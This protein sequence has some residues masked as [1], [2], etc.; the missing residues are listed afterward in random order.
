MSEDTRRILE[1]LSEGKISVEE[2][3]RL[4]AAVGGTGDRDAASSRSKDGGGKYLFVRV[5]PTEGSD[6]GGKGDRVN[7]RVPLA[8]LRAGAKL[9]ALMP[10]A[11]GVKVSDALSDHGIDFD[12]RKMTNEQFDEFINALCELEVN[13]DG[14]ASRV[15]VYVE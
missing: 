14:G 13:V 2:A 12:V 10:E 1:L 15:R 5:E 9:T 7:I 8:F 3:Q 6:E 4:L 11:A